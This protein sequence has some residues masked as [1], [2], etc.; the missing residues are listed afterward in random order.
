[1]NIERA[2][3]TGPGVAI[4][5]LTDELAQA[6]ALPAEVGLVQEARAGGWGEAE[7]GHLAVAAGLTIVEAA[8]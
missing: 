5:G 7:A 4:P 2:V 3:I 6:I 1:M 8:A